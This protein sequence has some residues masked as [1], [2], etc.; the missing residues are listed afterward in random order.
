RR[1]R[2]FGAAVGMGRNRQQGP[3]RDARGGRCAGDQAMS[4]LGIGHHGRDGAQLL[5][6]VAIAIRTA[7]IKDGMIHAQAGAGVVADSVPQ[8]EWDETVNKARAVMRAAADAAVVK[9]HP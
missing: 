9:I 8:S 4:A 3:R 5:G 6:S 7:V 2:R 1:G